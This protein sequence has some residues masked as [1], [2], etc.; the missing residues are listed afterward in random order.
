MSGI[1]HRFILDGYKDPKPLIEVDG[2][3]MIKHVIDLFPGI[4]DVVFICNEIHIKN[5]N[6]VDVLKRYSP[7][8]KIISTTNENRKG[9]VDAIY[10]SFNEVNDNKKIIVSY[11]DY[12]TKWDF[13]KFIDD[14]INRDLDGS[15]ACYTGFHPHMLGSDNYA[16]VNEEKLIA[17]EVK[18]KEPFTDNKMSEYA[19]NGTYFFKNGKILKKYFEKLI[20]EETTINGE[21]YVSL[22]YNSMIKDGLKIGVFEI[23]K[24]LQWG[25]PSDLRTYK[26]W[27]NYFKNSIG[28]KPTVECP[29]N[30]TLILPMSG[31]GSRFSDMGFNLPKPLIPVNN[32]IMVIEA[33]N[34][35]PKTENKIFVCLNEHIQ[36]FKIDKT[37]KKYYK[38]CDVV[39]IDEVTNGQACTCE[40]GINK[41]NID[42]DNPILISACDNGI[43]Y[44]NNKLQELIDN[45]NIDIIV[46]TFRNNETS[47]LNPNSY[48][49]LDVDDDGNIK[50][51]S[52]KK[53]IYENP[54]ETHAIIGTMFFR[55]AKY[56]VDG[57]KQN[58]L[59][60]I[61]TNNEYY[62]DDVLN[63]N[64]KN[65]LTVKI[66][67]VTNYICWG[68]PNDLKTYNY[69]KEFFTKKHKLK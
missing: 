23:D 45:T 29:N 68:A 57:L 17:L 41:S 34:C 12:G 1:G 58:Y 56:F 26:T 59:E 32:D 63:Q 39:V 19:S 20:K 54:L 4:T 31:R 55:K 61:T 13:L 27:S 33:V 7:T 15:I 42:T 22:V 50:H 5:T 30:T 49:W 36:D 10:K 62:V 35:L 9:P 43:F 25:T 8:C 37:L 60:N 16:F 18:E 2:Y 38:N 3:P 65:G 69:W 21:Y 46:W 6:I 40:I 66:F 24:M 44:D 14:T 11:C 28:W 64:I 67:E 51:V 52:C 53:F 47:R 48:A